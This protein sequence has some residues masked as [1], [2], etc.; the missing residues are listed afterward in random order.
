MLTVAQPLNS[1]YR[2][3]VAMS[4]MELGHAYVRAEKLVAALR[5]FREAEAIT[6][7]MASADPNNA[8][9]R[10]MQ[11]IELNNV[12]DVLRRLRRHREALAAH[13]KALALSEALAQADPANESYAFMIADTCQFMGETYLA[14][15]GTARSVPD[16]RDA[17]SNARSWYRRSAAVFEAMRERRT[18]TAGV[19]EEADP[20]SLAS[21]V[22][23]RLL[24]CDRQL[25]QLPPRE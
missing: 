1:A 20:R 19:T 9:A 21:R 2:N 23:Q 16:R 24:L 8:Q 15:A 5:S 14:M 12:G 6:A 17:W 13:A 22:S 18:L 4:S 11:G 25:R 10:W 7:S 3:E